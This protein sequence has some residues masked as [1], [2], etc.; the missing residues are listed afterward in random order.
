MEKILDV[1][2]VLALLYMIKTSYRVHNRY[3]DAAIKL[4]SAGTLLGLCWSIIVM[5][6]RLT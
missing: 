6:R 4:L 1:I 2:A 5:V 3:P